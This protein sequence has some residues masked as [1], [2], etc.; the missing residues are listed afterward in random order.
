MLMAATSQQPLST[1]HDALAL[2][3]AI[4]HRGRLRYIAERKRWMVWDGKRWQPD[5]T[6]LATDLVRATCGLEA[7]SV[8]ADEPPEVAAPVVHRLSNA[9]TAAAVERLARCDQT[10]AAG[11][12]Q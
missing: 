7:A 1:T 11:T 12:G 4:S 9:A 6:L 2:A 10:I 8:R 5:K 3:F